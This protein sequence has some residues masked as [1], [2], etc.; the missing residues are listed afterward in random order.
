MITTKSRW[1]DMYPEEHPHPYTTRCKSC[2]SENV[3][4]LTG[5]VAMRFAGLK[6]IDR[7]VVMVFPDFVVCLACGIAQ[8]AVPEAQLHALTKR[9]SAAG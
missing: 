7:P 4:K 3:A 8:F 5:E 9:Y 6:N 2:G 1:Q